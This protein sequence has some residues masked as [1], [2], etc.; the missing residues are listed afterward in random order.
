MVT[1]ISGGSHSGRDK[2]F[3]DKI[4]SAVKNGEQVMVII[5][6]QF[7]FEYD[8]KLYEHLGAAD[9]NVIQ[10]AGFNRIAEFT[11]KLYGGRAKE[12]ADDNVRTILMYKAVRRLKQTKDIRFYKK[13]LEKGSFL[14]ELNELVSQFRESG[15]TPQ[16]LA[17]A[18]EKQSGS[19]A[20]KLFDISRLYD[21]Y[22]DELEKAGMQDTLSAMARSVDQVKENGYFRG[23]T[24]FVDAFND[25]SFDELKM[26]DACIAQC[27]SITFSLCIDNES[28]RRY[29]NH[30]FADTLK[31]LQQITDISA[32]HNYK[33]NTV[34]CRNSS[35][36]VPE[37]E[38]VSKEIY[39]TC[40]KPYVGKC[41]NVS[42][43]SATDIYEESEFV[44][45]KIW[46]LVREKGYKFSSSCS[47]K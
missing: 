20:M 31:T 39:N 27:K 17:L 28:V 24:V 11:E 6:D 21:F 47:R 26:L 14:A 32:D 44:S 19:L 30:P 35:F 36:R 34:E 18:A 7:S 9:F 41:E 12:N 8:K 43:I 45:G 13:S 33:V 15:I 5:P 10:T 29:A 1:V 40:K 25:F 4:K 22:M 42:V 16:D 3:I 2:V 46:E 37:L 38:Y 23:M